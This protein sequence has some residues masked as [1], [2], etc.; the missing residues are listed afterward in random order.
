MPSVDGDEIWA[1]QDGETAKAFKAFGIY[2]SMAAN[3]RS[4]ARVAAQVGHR[5][6]ST[7]KGW[8]ARY[9]WVSRAAAWDEELDREARD[10][11]TK[12]L[13]E[14]RERHIG[15]SQD[16][17]KLGKHQIAQHQKKANK[18]AKSKKG[19]APVMTV[20]EAGSLADKGMRLERLNRGE[21]ETVTEE[22][23]R[24]DVSWSDLVDA[25]AQQAEDEK[26]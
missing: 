6:P 15:I 23:Q 26:S 22:H 8:S 19:G 7:C 9:Q 17:Q 21:P 16:M 11:E 5:Q 24:V 12:E 1:R 4:S 10:A 18:R 20:T 25:A 3:K 2:R 14:M 13:L